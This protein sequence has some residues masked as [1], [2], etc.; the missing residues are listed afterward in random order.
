M[1]GGQRW[2]PLRIG[3]IGQKGLPATFGGVEHHVEELGRRLAERGHRVTV[4]SRR[5]YTEQPSQWHLGMEVR[6]VP[7]IASKHLDAIV[8]SATS[9]VCAMAGRCDVLHYHALGPGL[10]APLPRA[11]SRAAVVQTVH[12][13]DHERAKWGR[14]AKAILGTAH[15]MSGRVPNRTIVVSRDLQ[16]HYR[17]EFGRDSA[18]I[19]NG[20]TPPDHTGPEPIVEQFGLAPGRYLLFVGRLVPEKA[21]DM[22]IRAYRQ[23]AGDHRLVI[24]G[25]SSFT[26]EYTRSLQLLIA[27]DPRVILTGFA[28]GQTLSAL[29]E[30]AGLFVQP[31]LLEGLPLTLLEAASHGLPILASDIP[32]HREVLGATGAPGRRLFAAGNE[33][34]LRAALIE[35]VASMLG[36]RIAAAEFG[37]GVVADYSWDTAALAVEDVYLDVAG[38]R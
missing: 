37:A 12:G 11:F 16:E 6:T 22:L 20:V 38:V 24:V 10:L 1:S 13:L 25:D 2:R 18:L 8:H 31:S 29:Y 7:T 32:P 21:P 34:S 26:D 35:A 30:H 33:A 23:I 15:W 14:P 5:G 36:D 28:F 19:P 3:M 4:F 17:R 9:T 27:D